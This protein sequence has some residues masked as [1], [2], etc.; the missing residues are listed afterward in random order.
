MTADGYPSDWRQRRQRV[1]K[2]DHYRCRNCRRY[3]CDLEVHHVVPKAN[4]GSH[5]EHNLV[6]LCDR[7]HSDVPRPSAEA[8]NNQD[9]GDTQDRTIFEQI[10]SARERK[11]KANALQRFWWWLFGMDLDDPAPAGDD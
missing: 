4:G 9:D 3:R 5:R 10:E 1:L 8:T 2:R 6:T 11:A 7:C